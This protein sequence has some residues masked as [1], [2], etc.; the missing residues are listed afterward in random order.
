MNI[1]VETK[2]NPHSTPNVTILV[3]ILILVVIASNL[4]LDP[5]LNSHGTFA[6]LRPDQ[7]VN[8]TM[9]YDHDEDLQGIAA[10]TASLHDNYTKAIKLR[11]SGKFKALILRK[12]DWDR[13]E[14]YFHRV[15]EMDS[16]FRDV[17]FQY[18]ILLRYRERYEEAIDHVYRQIRIKPEQHQP[19]VE[20]F[21]FYQHLITNRKY[22]QALDWLQK[23]SYRSESLYALGELY[24]KNDKHE[25]AEQLFK[26]LLTDTRIISKVPIY[27]SICRLYISTNQNKFISEYYWKSVSDIKN[28]VDVTL[29]FEDLKYIATDEEL[30]SFYS[31][32][33]ISQ[34]QTFVA[35]FWNKRNPI[36]AARINPRIIEHYNRIVY[37]EKYYQYYG[38]RTAFTNPDR[39]G[40][41][42][43]NKTYHLNQEFNDKGLIY[44][45]QG[46]PDDRVVSFGEG[47]P[48]NE[49]WLY[50]GTNQSSRMIFHFTLFNTPNF[51]RV[52]PIVENAAMLEDLLG[53][54]E[55]YF[56]MLNSQTVEQ[57]SL[58]HEMAI[59]NQKFLSNGLNRDRHTW[60]KETKPLDL[61]F[62]TASF[63][64]DSAK[65]L[66]EIYHGFDI[67]GSAKGDKETDSNVENGYSIQQ[68][69]LAFV[70]SMLR[71][72][73]FKALD[74]RFTGM[75]KSV[76]VPDSYIVSLYAHL[77]ESEYIGGYKFRV[78]VPDYASTD[79]VNISD[80]EIAYNIT[81]SGTSGLYEKQGIYIYPNPML[82]FKK[83]EP[84]HVYFEVYDLTLDDEGKT[85]YLI[86]YNLTL[87]KADKSFFSSILNVFDDK[88]GTSITTS[89][90]R[91]GEST[92]SNEYIALDVS[93]LSKGFY[94][95]NVKVTDTFNTASAAKERIIKIY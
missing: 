71:H 92:Q 10:D 40:Y 30:Q 65:T 29:L 20:I 94:K 13:S 2:S 54:D 93:N 38:F 35:D 19:R 75:F 42:T 21:R 36:P 6:A 60:S 9:S 79:S 85:R 50:L 95:L 51:W 31:K 52:T 88:P 8:D 72:D 80:L 70:D 64:G 67:P 62:Y 57:L 41:F 53:W 46:K 16:T 74:D 18:A 23:R 86:E 7:A 58:R 76:V 14:K 55:I 43:F 22:S 5:L 87:M 78:I 44:I 63:K 73:D 17:M 81:T 90:G 47:V 28:Y 84:V 48:S 26:Q 25:L 89:V 83:S 3:A 4:I 1:T 45:R 27:S 37:A 34:V 66:F 61:S 82:A 91:E 68:Y 56:R 33:T 12:L 11:E 77:T 39:L 32:H 49:S 15:M 59:K 69:D 24:R